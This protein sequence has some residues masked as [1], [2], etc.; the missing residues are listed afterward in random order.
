MSLLTGNSCSCLIGF[1]KFGKDLGRNWN[2][3]VKNQYNISQTWRLEE[4]KGEQKK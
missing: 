2:G 1:L 3:F 4:K